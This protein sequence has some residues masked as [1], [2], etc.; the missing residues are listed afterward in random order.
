MTGARA[1]EAASQHNDPIDLLL[2][3]VIMPGMSGPDLA[4][5]LPVTPRGPSAVR[6]AIRVAAFAASYGALAQVG[7]LFV[8]QPE[9][10]PAF[11]PAIG[12][13]LAA[14][15]M[16]PA[17]DWPWLAL[18]FYL[19]DVSGARLSGGETW[20]MALVLAA[21]GVSTPGLC[22]WLIREWP[23]PLRPSAGFRALIGRILAWAVVVSAAGATLG[24]AIGPNAG[25]PFRERWALWWL[26][27]LA[28]MTLV[29]PAI[30]S[31]QPALGGKVRIRWGR[32]AEGVLLGVMLALLTDFLFGYQAAGQPSGAIP[33]RPFPYAVLPPLIWAAFRFGPRGTSALVLVVAAIA[34][35]CTARGLGP[36]ALSGQSPGTHALH[37]Q[38][39]VIVIGLSAIVLAVILREREHVVD[40][41]VDSEERYRHLF[42]DTATVMLTVDPANGRILDANP[43]AEEFYGWTREECRRMRVHDINTATPF[44]I[45][46]A[47]EDVRTRAKRHFEFR[48]RLKSGEVRDVEIYSSP[49]T[50]RGRVV[51]L[52]MVLDVTARKRVE[53]ALRHAQRLESLGVLAGGVAHDFTN[54]L[55]VMLG[56]T[57]AALDGVPPGSGVRRHLDQ[58]VTAIDRATELAAKMR[59]YSGRGSFEVGPVDVAA[60]VRH[61][62]PLLQAAVPER[63]RLTLSL[64]PA[65][66]PIN[67]DAAQIGQALVAIVTNAVEAIGERGGAISVAIATRTIDQEEAERWRHTAT[68]IEPGEYVSIEIRDD[69]CGMSAATLARVFDP[70]FTTKFVGRGLG[71]AAVLGIVRGHRGGIAVESALGQGTRVE[72]L[73]PV[74]DGSSPLAGSG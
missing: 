4:E 7:F 62:Q 3:D 41:L 63:V 56:H 43:A 5:S 59:A 65:L 30:L 71:L 26:V 47:M 40:A 33:F 55:T 35:W 10:I 17:R 48:H 27:S 12:V 1:I 6:R 64:P 46:M 23:T 42:E 44:E 54:L 61:D 69:G 8:V 24:A 68:P 58:A 38:L 20:Q 9:H 52:S 57:S 25:V 67:G 32:L 11:W 21:L 37:T 31:W 36:F 22:A 2:T 18:A 16:T 34:A 19:I 73:L 53:E 39:F 51:L 28:G 13:A 74:T 60:L 45:E 72:I 14:F 15:L 50:I 29:A 49:V 70:F 66:P